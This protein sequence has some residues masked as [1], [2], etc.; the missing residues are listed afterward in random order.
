MVRVGAYDIATFSGWCGDDPNR[1]EPCAPRFGS[2]RI[3]H[4]GDCLGDAYVQFE[5]YVLKTFDLLKP[6]AVAFEAPLPRGGKKFHLKED[7][8]A[9]ARK[10]LGL[11]AI[12]ELIA[13]RAGLDVY[14]CTVSQARASLCNGGDDKDRVNQ[15][16]RMYGWTPANLDESD[17]GAVWVHTKRHLDP[18]WYRWFCRQSIKAVPLFA[19]AR[20]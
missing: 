20:A 17:A 10:L 8:A 1:S 6:D 7:S 11:A 14:E 16:C 2:F 19:E 5:H 9:A 4:E 13:T 3:A 18:D 12:F 15:I